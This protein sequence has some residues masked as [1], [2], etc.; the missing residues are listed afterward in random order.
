MQ[1]V[2]L[3]YDARGEDISR[4]MLD[5]ALEMRAMLKDARTSKSI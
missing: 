2:V 4:D 3:Y 5:E 1:I